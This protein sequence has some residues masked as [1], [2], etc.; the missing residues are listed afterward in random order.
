[1]TNKQ[2]KR[3]LA[4]AM[5]ALRPDTDFD[6]VAGA[7][8]APA[9]R[10]A[11]VSRP[12]TCGMRRYVAAVAAAAVMVAGVGVWW[13]TRPE[14][15]PPIAPSVDNPVDVP[16]DPTEI[17]SL[18]EA[19]AAIA[20]GL[21]E[22]AYR[23]LLTDTS[24]EAA[25]L[26]ARFSYVLLGGG[27]NWEIDE[28]GKLLSQ[29]VIPDTSDSDSGVLVDGSVDW[30]SDVGKAAREE[31]TYDGNG[32][33]LTMAMVYVD[34]E[35]EHRE[36][37]AYTYDAAGN[38]AKKVFT[39][40]DGKTKTWVYTYDEKGRCIKEESSGDGYV[41][42]TITYAYDEADRLLL[43]Y[44]TFGGSD[45]W[46]KTEYT[47]DAKGNLLKNAY[48]TSNG[49][50]WTYEYTYD[51]DGNQTSY[52]HT[53]PDEPDHWQKWYMEG[54]K[55]ISE[56]LSQGYIYEK[57]I[58]V[59]GKCIYSYFRRGSDVTETKIT[60]DEQGNRLTELTWFGNSNGEYIVYTYDDH[61]N[62]LQ[63][64]A[65]TITDRDHPEETA[66]LYK[67]WAAYSYV[68]D[69]D[70]RILQQEYT[71]GYDGSVTKTEYTYDAAGRLL[72]HKNT[73]NNDT[74]DSITHTYHDNGN[75][76]STEKIN[77]DG[78]WKKETFDASG[79]R[80]SM[81]D[82]EGKKT[83][84]EWT[85]CYYTQN[86]TEQQQNDLAQLRLNAK[87]LTGDSMDLESE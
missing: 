20:Q 2:L 59:D 68:Y 69:T 47:Y 74:W 34:G 46:H 76:K 71:D 12:R 85:L 22:D 64:T 15:T 44:E 24:E 63:R 40:T 39:A 55:K 83:T 30:D 67:V 41:Y 16:T 4:Q 31:Y 77:A 18:A 87:R 72:T 54:D 19:K 37:Y 86:L 78:T 80:L 43:R 75:V 35:E 5:G 13:H 14:D 23:Y 17:T 10:P 26:L 28:S 8:S 57:S 48:L 73:Y 7:I 21:Y 82:S 50:G 79:N 60:Y 84:Y 52:S 1:M 53:L 66:T 51:A 45:S 70:G 56:S 38:M 6:T 61:N 36:V 11:S 27:S 58:S 49:G 32:R 42:G 3:R 62:L 29:P 65:Y 33:V 9:D 25:A 81:E